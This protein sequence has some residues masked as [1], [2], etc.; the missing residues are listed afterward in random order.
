MSF[1]NRYFF[2]LGFGGNCVHFIAT[3]AHYNFSGCADTILFSDTGHSHRYTKANNI[4]T[5]GDG[6]FTITDVFPSEMKCLG[7]DTLTYITLD[8]E[9]DAKFSA[10]N[11]Y[12]KVMYDETQFYDSFYKDKDDKPDRYS[13]EVYAEYGRHL[14]RF[15]LVLL[16]RLAQP[17]PSTFDISFSDIYRNKNKIINFIENLTQ[18]QSSKMLETNYDNYLEL[19]KKILI[20]KAPWFYYDEG[21]YYFT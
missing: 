19:Q 20:E 1:E 15:T 3:L 4:I 6:Q 18:K 8:T 12:L 7:N 2:Y 13:Q 10:I 5:K 11:H 21:K 17:K 16:P 14:K 9:L